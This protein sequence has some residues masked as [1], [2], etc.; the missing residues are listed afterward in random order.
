ML[1]TPFERRLSKGPV[2]WKKGDRHY[3]QRPEP[4]ATMGNP[5]FGLH[6]SCLKS[7]ILDQ[8]TGCAFLLSP[9]TKS[10]QKHGANPKK[11]T[12]QKGHP[13]KYDTESDV[14]LGQRS[15]VPRTWALRDFR[16][17]S[18]PCLGSWRSAPLAGRR[19]GLGFQMPSASIKRRVD[20]PKRMVDPPPPKKQN[21]R[22]PQ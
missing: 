15:Q 4:I 21:G 12:I 9:Q 18:R 13:P 14:A 6:G 1:H 11:G 19:C 20:P 8:R 3:G 2:H 5:G 10:K 16:R 22:P 7:V 17:S